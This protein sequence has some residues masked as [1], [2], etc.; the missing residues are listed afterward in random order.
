MNA[1]AIISHGA[2]A[3]G[4]SLL[5]LVALGDGFVAGMIAGMYIVRE[6]LNDHALPHV[7]FA[8]VVSNGPDHAAQGLVPLVVAAAL[9]LAWRVFH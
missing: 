8:R 2:I 5:S 4:V 6:A 3:F 9:T 1:P 7:Y